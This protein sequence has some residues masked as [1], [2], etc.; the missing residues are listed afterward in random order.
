M[1][2]GSGTKEQV[3][4]KINFLQGILLFKHSCA[5]CG[6]IKWDRGGRE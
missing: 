2:R 4:C 1:A 6:S 3:K 5:Q